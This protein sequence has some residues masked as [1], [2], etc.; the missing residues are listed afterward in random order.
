MSQR[1]ATPTNQNVQNYMN[2]QQQRINNFSGGNK[3]QTKEETKKYP[4]FVDPQYTNF[5]GCTLSYPGTAPQG[6]DYVSSNQ[7]PHVVHKNYEQGYSN[8]QSNPQYNYD[9]NSIQQTPSMPKV[10][11]E[12]FA[13]INDLENEG[14][15]INDPTND[16]LD[17]KTRPISDFIHNNMVPFYGGSVKQNMAGTGVKSGNYTDGI[18]VDNGFDHTTPYQNK[19][20]TFTGLDDTYLHKREVGPLYS[21]AEQQMGWVYGSPSFRPDDDRYSQS[22][23]YRNDLK[24][25]EPEMVGPG[26][27]L[28]AEIPAAGGFHDQTR[29]LPNNVNDYK[30]NQLEGRVKAGKWQLGGAEPTAY[31]GVGVSGD[32]RDNRNIPGV[33]KNRPNKFWTQERRPTMTAKVGFVDDKELLRPDYNVSKRPNNALRSQ[34]NYGFGELVIED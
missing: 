2:L 8:V 13:N 3:M 29:V 4:A 28:D 22:I 1:L 21:P 17:I 32:L 20:A 23:V 11:R 7:Y 5:V 18:N 31:P 26:L 16:L 14:T 9:I 25:C 15:P 33:V 10:M 19:L 12:G 27:A 24:P 6:L 30:A 34:T